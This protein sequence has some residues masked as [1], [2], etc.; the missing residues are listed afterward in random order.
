MPPNSPCGRLW[1]QPSSWSR[2]RPRDPDS[3]VPSALLELADGVH[4][5]RTFKRP[6]AGGRLL[7]L[8]AARARKFLG[9][10]GSMALDGGQHF[11]HGDLPDAVCFLPEADGAVVR[12]GP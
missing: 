9:V 2:L 11:R 8:G 3:V 6:A 4:D 12:A 7:C 10:S 5:R 1:L